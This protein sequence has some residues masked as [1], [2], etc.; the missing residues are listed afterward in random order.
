[1]KNKL[2]VLEA[3]Y[4]MHIFLE[5]YFKITSSDSI[6][7]LLS[8]MHFLDDGEPADSAFW[9]DWLKITDNKNVTAIQAFQS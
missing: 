2:T 3:F 7:A 6:G 9:E 4:A 5:D 8:C 1:M